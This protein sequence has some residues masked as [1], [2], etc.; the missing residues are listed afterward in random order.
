MLIRAT[1]RSRAAYLTLF[2]VWSAQAESTVAGRV[3]DLQ[4]TVAPGATVRL[5]TL[6]ASGSARAGAG[7]WLIEPI[8]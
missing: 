8:G 3:F 5:E 4:G 1:A 2:L 7:E 6:Q